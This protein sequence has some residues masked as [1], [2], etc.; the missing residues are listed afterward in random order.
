[1]A[2]PLVWNDEQIVYAFPS[3]HS[4]QIRASKWWP[5][6]QATSHQ[7]VANTILEKRHNKTSTSNAT[8]TTRE[9]LHET[10]KRQ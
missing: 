1:L 7:R 8:Q 9:T 3:S 4:T 10:N 2:H 6:S 5:C